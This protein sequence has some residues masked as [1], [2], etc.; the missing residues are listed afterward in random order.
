MWILR[1]KSCLPTASG[2]HAC[3]QMQKL[4]TRKFH[5]GLFLKSGQCMPTRE[6]SALSINVDFEIE[7]VPAD[8]ITLPFFLEAETSECRRFWAALGQADPL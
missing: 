7:I 5:D 4:T 3:G 8:G 2:C 6:V 1:L